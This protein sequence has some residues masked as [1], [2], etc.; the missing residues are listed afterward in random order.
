MNT[1]K[2]E[3]SRNSIYMQPDQD[4]QVIIQKGEQEEINP[5][6]LFIYLNGE[7]IKFSI[8]EIDE[9]K[10]LALLIQKNEIIPD[11][12]ELGY[13]EQFFLKYKEFEERFD[14]YCTCRVQEKQLSFSLNE[15]I[16]TIVYWS[17]FFSVISESIAIQNSSIIENDEIRQQLAQQLPVYAFLYT[18]S[19]QIC[20]K[21]NEYWIWIVLFIVL[22]IVPV[23]VLVG[24]HLN[25]F[26]NYE[27][28]SGD[29]V[30]VGYCILSIAI[31]INSI[32]NRGFLYYIKK[33]SS[34]LIATLFNC[35]FCV[36]VSYFIIFKI[37]AFILLIESTTLEYIIDNIIQI[38]APST[39][40]VI[41]FLSIFLIKGLFHIPQKTIR[42]DLYQLSL[43]K[44]ANEQ[45]Q[46]DYLNYKTNKKV[47]TL[48]K[49]I[50]LEYIVPI[51]ISIFYATIEIICYIY[52][53][54]GLQ[55]Y[56]FDQIITF[57][58]LLIGI[59]IFIILGIVIS[60]T[61]FTKKNLY[62]FTTLLFTVVLS[63]IC[64]KVWS[65]TFENE[66]IGSISRLIGICPLIISLMWLTVA[67]FRS[68]KKYQKY[69]VMFFSCFSFALPLGILLTFYE[70]FD[71]QK[72][73]IATI[74]LL[75]I[76]I[77]P[78]LILI[79]YYIFVV[80]IYLIKLPQQAEKLLFTAYE[81]VNLN[82]YA[83]WYNSICYIISFYFICYFAWNEPITA[84]GTKKGTIIGLLSIH[85][86]LF[87]LTNHALSFEAK[88]KIQDE[89]QLQNQ[90]KP[91]RFL[92][93]IS[94]ITIVGSIVPFI[95]LMPIG[96]SVDNEVTKNALLANA[97]GLPLSFLYYKYQ[98]TL[99]QDSIQYQNF[100]QPLVVILVW[101]FIL[102]PIGTIFPILADYYEN[103]SS[104]FAIF[105]QLAVAYSILII[106]ISVTVL[107]IFYSVLLNKEELEKRKKEVLK[108]VMEQFA[109]KGVYATEEISSLLFVR[110]VQHRDSVKLKN[111]LTQQGDPVNMYEHPEPQENGIK[112]ILVTKKD[113]EN[114][115]KLEQIQNN[116]RNRYRNS[117]S[118][119][120]IDNQSQSSADTM[121]Q[122]Q[123]QSGF[124]Y[125]IQDFLFSCLLCKIG[126]YE[127][128]EMET[129]EKLKNDEIKM[130]EEV[131]R[132]KNKKL[133]FKERSR[134]RNS[135]I[136]QEDKAEYD[137]FKP[138]QKDPQRAK[139]FWQAIYQI[140]QK[141]DDFLLVL[142]VLALDDDFETLQQYE[143]FKQ[144]ND[145][146]TLS[147]ED[148]AL[149]IYDNFKQEN[150]S[151]LQTLQRIAIQKYFLFQD[152]I[153][154]LKN[155]IRDQKDLR[156]G[157]EEDN[158]IL[159]QKFQEERKELNKISP[160][161]KD[162]EESKNQY[163]GQEQIE[164]L[165]EIELEKLNNKYKIQNNP[166]EFKKKIWQICKSM[167][168]FIWI[169][170][171]KYTQRFMNQLA[172]IYS[173]LAPVQPEKKEINP[174]WQAIAPLI[175][176]S[177]VNEFN[178]F[179]K[180]K[181]EQV[182]H[183]KLTITNFLAVF[184]R[185][186][187]LYGLITLAFD[188]QVGWMGNNNSEFKPIK[189]VDYS[190]I[191]SQ[192]NFFFFMAIL[193]S[194]A[195]IILGLQASKQ[196]ADNTFGYDENRQIAGITSSRFWV[197]KTIQI[198]SGQFIFV[199]KTYIDSFICDYSEYPY[200]LIRQPSVEC[201]SDFHFLYI[202]FAII[203]CGIYYPLSTY[204]Q[205]TFQFMDRSLDFKFKSNFVVLYIQAKLLILGSSSVFSNL[206]ESSYLYQMLLDFFVM[207]GLDLRGGF[208]EDNF[209]LIQKFQEER[210]EL[211]KI[212]PNEKDNEE[213]KNQYQGQEQIEFLYEIELEK[214]NNKYKIQNNPSEFKKKIWQICKSMH[215]FIWIAPKKYTQRFMNQ[216]A[217]IYSKLAP[218][219]P[220]K[221]EINPDWQAIAPLI[222][223]SLVNEFNEFDKRKNEQVFHFKL[224]ITNFLA[225]FLRVYDLYGLIT[226][227][228]DS[229]VGWMGNN[230]SEFKPIKMVD[231]SAIWSQ[232]NFFFFMAILMSF[233]YII[234]GLQASKQIADNTFGYDENRQIAGITSSR[235]WVSKTIQ[236]ISGQ[237]IFVMKTYI[238]SFIC[239][240]SEYPYTL[241]RQ[242]SVEC[243]SDFH[244]L[245]ISFAIIGC[246][247]Y[248]PLSTYLQPTFQFMD[249]S[250]DFKFKSN[251]VVLYIQAKLLILGSSSVFSNLQESSYLY[252]ML[253]DFFVMAGLVYFHYKLDPCYIKW[254]N[255][256]DRSLLLILCYFYFGAFVIMASKNV[257]AGWVISSVFTVCTLAYLAY[258][259]IKIFYRNNNKNSVMPI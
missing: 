53:I 15:L 169:A 45:I 188:S 184:L 248:Y 120:Q 16:T 241:I 163:Q 62:L 228:F 18:L 152:I 186:Y 177:L 27:G 35:S 212:S 50:K 102:G 44:Y 259:L 9:A 21:R 234:L 201:M 48:F 193:M 210:K 72:F 209:I 25:L 216:L 114:K 118:L 52:L 192:Y 229:Q 211:N 131:K 121:K 148:F 32:I 254:F 208:E 100:T 74:V 10:E 146:F 82:N 115:K 107:S 150:E 40:I 202:S 85:S 218:V 156:G 89:E 132:K 175:V 173:K 1:V 110:F 133:T 185:V 103:S 42:W 162:N 69:L 168:T 207:A 251:F 30:G 176:D 158:F 138:L 140:F 7:E 55:S 90:I 222:V 135:T 149:L 183:F 179:D 128:E 75:C 203:G 244:F 171:K 204:L 130:L 198:I 237:F 76:G 194:F 65:M 101:T 258:S 17:T 39:F 219:Q 191:W 91:G 95:V 255:V 127:L 66:Y 77:I 136:L 233:A 116:R 167:H 5:Q 108:V 196:I 59:P 92:N 28:F 24:Y 6:S 70:Y 235:F 187:D 236:I 227:A 2:Q 106:I 43:L 20:Q 46:K 250:L 166:S 124:W 220:E 245:Y 56:D 68:E 119:T 249:R 60:N 87:I 3:R 47:T 170:P 252:Q 143:S 200:T 34:T 142:E 33:I 122:Q 195:Y 84:T 160:N 58:F 243:M 256:V 154:D 67:F 49:K 97:I 104:E 94:D 23:S 206:Q 126:F 257:A 64:I 157:F 139:R 38:I 86:V 153:P 151:Y 246:G 22:I 134:K 83:V 225:V 242:P 232:Y 247:I 98:M 239:D 215:T 93:R 57:G 99:K 61:R 36:L 165:Y 189:M 240:Y 63:V 172:D 224:T 12:R 81:Y 159:I 4:Q 54:T 13:V 26:G 182:F 199:M 109:K 231:Y 88:E 205:P 238:D 8:P 31:F 113:Y 141:K 190:A 80:S 11:A 78:I 96:L 197:S 145:N 111:D 79:I 144:I 221:K 213:S 147:A 14:T 223:D 155:F 164:F 137:Q 230:N 178:E 253:L 29:Y 180:R 226:L 217:D 123:E 73:Y 112:Y 174:D 117:L 125:T 129:N 41:F 214:L 51:F 105:A 161:E 181:N 19:S 37:I 71:D